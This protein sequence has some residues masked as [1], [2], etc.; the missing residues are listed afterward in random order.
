MPEK[1]PLF[2]VDMIA[3]MHRRDPGIFGVFAGIGSLEAVV[4]DRADDLEHISSRAS[5]GMANR[6]A[7]SNELLRLVHPSPSRASN[8]GV[9]TCHCRSAAR[10]AS[11]TAVAGHCRRPLSARSLLPSTTASGRDPNWAEAALE[12]LHDT[13]PSRSAARAATDEIAFFSDHA[14]W[15]LMQLHRT[16]GSRECMSEASASQTTPA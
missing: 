14:L 13:A 15:A 2:A 8:G 11:V 6:P 5:D 10:R 7:G 4:R 3:G 9:W 1:N 12:L 16:R